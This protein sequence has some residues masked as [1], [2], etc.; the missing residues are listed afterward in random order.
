MSLPKGLKI[1]K[2]CNNANIFNNVFSTNVFIPRE[3]NLNHKTFSYFTGFIKLVE[4]FKEM[5][6]NIVEKDWGLVIFCDNALFQ[7]KS[8]DEQILF[9]EPHTNNKLNNRLTPMKTKFK[10]NKEVITKLYKLYKLY[11]NHI[12][13]NPTDYDFVK[14]YTFRDTNLEN[15]YLG[16]PSTYGSFIRFIPLFTEFTKDDTYGINLSEEFDNIKK[17][18][19]INISHSIT[20]NLIKLINDWTDAGNPI[21]TRDIGKYKWPISDYPNEQ[22]RLKIIRTDTNNESF[23]IFHRIPAGL[24]GIDKSIK[25]SFNLFIKYITNL[26]NAYNECW[27]QSDS[28]IRSSAH[29]RTG[30]HS[31]SASANSRTSAHSST[32]ANSKTSSTIKGRT[33]NGP[34]TVEVAQTLKI[35]KT[36]FKYGI[37]EIILVALFYDELT[38]IE[39]ENCE[40]NPNF[41]CFKSTKRVE[42]NKARQVQ[43]NEIINTVFNVDKS[44][45]MGNSEYKQLFEEFK[46]ILNSDPPNEY[47]NKSNTNNLEIYID[48]ISEDLMTKLNAKIK[49]IYATNFN[50]AYIDLLLSHSSSPNNI[51]ECIDSDDDTPASLPIKKPYIIKYYKFV[52]E[53]IS[54]GSHNYLSN[55][56]LTDLNNIVETYPDPHKENP[57]TTLLNIPPSNT[58][59]YDFLTLLE[60]GHN[61][62]KPLILYSNEKNFQTPPRGLDFEYYLNLI[63][64]DD[65]TEDE[66]PNLLNLIRCHYKS[67]SVDCN[68]STTT[69][70]SNAT[71]RKGNGTSKVT[72]FIRSCKKKLLQKKDSKKGGSRIRLYKKK[73]FK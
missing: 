72:K 26:T 18:F 70:S 37:D 38:V 28:N 44:K 20:E 65:Y 42:N 22:K 50:S 27:P 36:I 34:Q 68:T 12:I 31:S 48:T 45:I 33:G 54:K 24:F 53:K 8:I 67:E 51:E 30:A 2:I 29:S 9:Y 11:I 57:F 32:G 13:H 35:K 73:N 17:V 19:C 15:N 63:C 55:K 69:I 7:E 47:Y 3:L 43:V 49:S 41:F 52:E 40:I 4:T 23:K 16:L 64:I 6:T 66:L 21:C 60:N 5:T 61:Q 58:D 59:T 1:N 56:F 71:P 62:S 39:A 14:I 46:K 10:E 25:K